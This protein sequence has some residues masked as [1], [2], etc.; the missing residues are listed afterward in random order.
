MTT[1]K[2]TCCLLITALALSLAAGAIWA[3]SEKEKPDN[4]GGDKILA[5]VGGK[6]LLFSDF[7]K[8][9]EALPEDKREKLTP[10]GKR[11]LV[12]DWVLTRLLA[13]EAERRNVAQ[14]EQVK[15]KL[16][17]SRIKILSDEILL[18][19]SLKVT[20][21]DEDVARYFD[22]H[23]ELFTVPETVRLGVITVTTREEAEAALKRLTGGEDFGEVARKVSIDK[24]KN[25]G[26][27]AGVLPRSDK[28]PDYLKAVFY[29]R[30]GNLSDVVQC[31]KGYCILK[32]ISKSSAKSLDFSELTPSM[33]SAIQK[34]ALREKRAE[35]IL[36][37]QEKLANQIGVT[38]NL[39]LLEE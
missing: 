35:A 33:K 3:A 37:L 20:I 25:A 9:V 11:A 1:Q 24:F 7:K 8:S 26:G 21:T 30:E 18:E 22:A 14:R 38:K 29:L 17:N 5:S 10:A 39:D 31:E 6:V 36:Q 4:N 13:A 27:E 34:R 16:E 15:S 32:P 23:R 28:L 12:E 19:E 2:A